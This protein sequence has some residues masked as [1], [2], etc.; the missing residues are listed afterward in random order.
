VSEVTRYDIDISR[1]IGEWAEWEAE[2][3]PDGNWVVYDD[4]AD[5]ESEVA[6]LRQENER[7]I[8]GLLTCYSLIQHLPC[9]DKIKKAD[10]WESDF[11]KVIGIINVTLD[12]EATENE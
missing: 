6:K 4:C 3:H 8:D 9:D 1:L 11:K 10:G 7:L 2:E 12:A 5:L